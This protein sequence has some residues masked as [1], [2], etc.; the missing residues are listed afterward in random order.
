MSVS[1]TAV[2]VFQDLMRAEGCCV[3]NRR[4]LNSDVD[5]TGGS[6]GNL[7]DMAEGGELPTGVVRVKPIGS[8]PL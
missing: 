8:E 1:G 2:R 7:E 6:L 5:W 3:A 4:E